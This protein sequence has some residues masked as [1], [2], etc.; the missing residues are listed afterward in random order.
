MLP[1]LYPS[2]STKND[3]LGHNGLGFLK[4]SLTCEV[5]RAING[6]YEISGTIL[7]TDRLAD[8]LTP[9]QY[10]K[11]PPSATEDAQ[12]FEIYETATQGNSISYKGQHIRY[13]L[14]SNAFSESYLPV[15]A[16]TPVETWNA[17]QEYFIDENTDFTFSSTLT[18]TGIPWAAALYP[19]RVGDFLLGQQGSM[20][21]TYGGEYDFDNFAITLKSR[22]GSDTGYCLRCGAGIDSAE[23]S[24]NTDYMY[25]HISAY[26]TLPYVLSTTGETIGEFTVYLDAPISTGGTLLSYN[27]YLLY[28]FSETY[29]SYDTQAKVL[30]PNGTYP[31][32]TSLAAAKSKLTSLVNKYISRN[33]DVLTKPTFNAEIKPTATDEQ[34]KQLVLGDTVYIYYEPFNLQSQAR[35]I[36][37]T[38]DVLGERYKNVEIGFTKKNL[39]NLFSNKN[40]GGH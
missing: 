30:T 5:S 28:D 1:I 7:A 26:A 16:R 35:V 23:Y 37:T 34:V 24:V 6:E 12:I 13:K 8:S 9:M 14:A 27:R 10:V 33:S 31:D 4:D 32:S 3:L 2:T 11:A 21:D 22:L 19:T 20:L 18:T 29:K 17:I 36:S 38:Y 15:V 39:A 25:S 40:I